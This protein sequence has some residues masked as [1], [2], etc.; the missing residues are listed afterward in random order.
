MILLTELKIQGKIAKLKQKQKI[1]ANFLR[2][3]I[4]RLHI[5]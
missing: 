1:S 3:M 4:I 2:G 5:S